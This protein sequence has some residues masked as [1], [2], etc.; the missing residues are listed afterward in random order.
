ME[1]YCDDCMSFLPQIEEHSIDMICVDLP[2]Q[3]TARNKWDIRLPMEDFVLE[4]GKILNEEQFYLKR[5]KNHWSYSDAKKLWE[6]KK[7][8]GL[9]TEYKRIL[10]ERGIIVLFG[11]GEF[12]SYLIQSNPKWYRYSLIWHKTQPSGF[13]N[14]R[15]MPLR[16]HEDMLI[17]YKKLP[18]YHPQMT[19]NHERKVSSASSKIHSKESSNYGTLD[20][21]TSY[22]STRRFPT[23]I[24]TFPKDTQ[25]AA[26]H[27]TQKPVGLLEELILTYTNEGDVVLDHCMGSG[28]CGLACKN[29]RREFIGVEKDWDY[30]NIARER[31][32]G[33]KK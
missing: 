24:W 8:N 9:W 20:R 30:F 14:A 31:I 4:E 3:Q 25:K 15:R 18:V 22:D 29:T 10:K 11:N 26:L 16:T 2:Y 7:Q 21:L 32:I 1:L 13:L 33:E 6:E 5:F 19:E 27:P 12:S 28:S 23:S 17:F